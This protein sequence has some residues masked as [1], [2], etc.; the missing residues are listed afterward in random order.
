[1]AAV[2]ASFEH[3]IIYDASRS[4]VHAL[5]LTGG[6][7]AVPPM[8]ARFGRCTSQGE[9][10]QNSPASSIRRISV[11]RFRGILALGY[12]CVS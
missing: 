9:Q 6:R 2:F 8:P 7:P 3:D 1:M 5:N 10:K 11:R 12:F 4:G